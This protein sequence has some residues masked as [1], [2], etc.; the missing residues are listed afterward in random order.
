LAEGLIEAAGIV[1]APKAVGADDIA[2]AIED[3]KRRYGS[4]LE[5]DDLFNCSEYLYKNSVKAT[6]YLRAGPALKA[7]YIEVWKRGLE[8]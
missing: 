3:I 4:I 7:R 8:G 1:A 2:I 6:V 5:I